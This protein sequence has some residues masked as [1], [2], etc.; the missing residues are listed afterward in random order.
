MTIEL[1]NAVEV[2]LSSGRYL[3]QTNMTTGTVTM[4]IS[5]S[6]DRGKPIAFQ[7]IT[8]GSFSADSDG[9][10]TLTDCRFRVNITGDGEF[11]IGKVGR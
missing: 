11:F 10:I 1:V 3:F 9:E 2:P 8:D 4:Q 5:L 6:I 7:D